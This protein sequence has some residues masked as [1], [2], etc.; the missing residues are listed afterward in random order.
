M[1]H[2]LPDISPDI[3]VHRLLEAYPELE[4][5]LIDMAPPFKK[6]RN[7]VLR[8][9]VAKIATL[10]QAAAVGNLSLDFM[11]KRL[12]TAAGLPDFESS[13]EGSNYLNEQPPWFSEE[14]IVHSIRES[15]L[16]ENEMPIAILLRMATSIQPTEIIELET[17]FI[18][19]PGI[20]VM[21]SKGYKAWCTQIDQTTY[22]SFFM[23]VR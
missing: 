2:P 15:D 6:L 16:G 5:V 1:P 8:R 12:R 4:E 3:T 22:K 13:E 14:N 19:A 23:K 17:T 9:S 20:D 21:K 10:K 18:P 7:P 11:I